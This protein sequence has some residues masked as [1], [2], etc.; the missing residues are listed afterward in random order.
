MD[1]PIVL[2]IIFGSLAILMAAGLPVAITFMAI[3]IVGAIILW[4]GGVGLQMLVTHMLRAVGNFLFLP[5]PMFVLMGE[6]L[7]RSGMA[8]KVIATGNPVAIKIAKL[9]KI[10]RRTMGQSKCLSPPCYRR[11]ICVVITST[12]PSF[13]SFLR[14]L[15][16]P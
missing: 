16:N 8:M 3:N 11:P 9:P 2:L 5:I 13:C 1:W 10:M 15:I 4:D 7:F 12:G 6:L 14:S